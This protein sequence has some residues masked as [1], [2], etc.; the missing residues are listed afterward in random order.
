MSDTTRTVGFIVTWVVLI[1]TLL[2]IAPT[3]VRK[4]RGRF[5][6]Q[7]GEFLPAG[8][9]IESPDGHHVLRMERSGNLV[10]SKDGVVRWSS[11]TRVPNSI[12]VVDNDG[13][14]VIQAPDGTPTWSSDIDGI[15]PDALD[16]GDTDQQMVYDAVDIIRAAL[17]GPVT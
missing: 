13:T 6:L 17:P 15:E 8:Q 9:D 1:A 2:Q 10:L 3:V 4:Q 7:P 14:L 11:G 12:L 16:L 5:G